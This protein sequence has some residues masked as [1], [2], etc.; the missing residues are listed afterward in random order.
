MK[1]VKSCAPARAFVPF[2][3]TLFFESTNDVTYF[4]NLLLHVPENWLFTQQFIRT[5]RDALDTH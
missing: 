3:L 1:V 5:I 4:N 2:E